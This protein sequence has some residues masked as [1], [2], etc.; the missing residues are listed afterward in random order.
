MLEGP[1]K[2]VCSI[3]HTTAPIGSP[4][5]RDSHRGAG[6]QPWITRSCDH[7]VIGAQ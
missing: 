6:Q 7:L 1:E 3:L 4:G 2:F 5:L